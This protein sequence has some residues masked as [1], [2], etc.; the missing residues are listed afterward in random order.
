[1]QKSIR[2]M[3]ATAICVSLMC[4]CALISLPL[5]HISMSLQLFAIYF[6]LYY[7]G[8]LYGTLS[9]VVYL[10]L[11]AIGLP[12]F[13]SFGGGI[14]AFVGPSGG[15]LFG[16]L[17]LALVYSL[18]LSLLSNTWGGKIIATVLSLLALYLFGS[19]Y[20]SMVYLGGLDSI[21]ASLLATVL[22]FVLPDIAKIALAFFLAGR[23]TLLKK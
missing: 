22:P 6:A 16:F 13:S 7:L 4:I 11:G 19:V 10:L 21:G 5:G 3:T 1:M 23:I 20:Y 9:V 2:K 15:F 14:S 18:S 12:V 8:P 17:A